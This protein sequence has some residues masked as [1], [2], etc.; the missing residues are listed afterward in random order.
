MRALEPEHM[1]PSHTRPV[2]GAEQISEILTAYRDAIQYVH[3]QTIR[4]MNRGLTPD[5]L[6]EEVRLPPH[7]RRGPVQLPQT[8]PAC[9]SNLP[10][11][12]RKV[13]KRLPASNRRTAANP[14]AWPWKMKCPPSPTVFAFSPERR[15]V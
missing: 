10:I 15:A 2:S 6:V 8:G 13:Q 3:D 14:T 7:L 9:C 12:S 5:E 11:A 4:G 1:A